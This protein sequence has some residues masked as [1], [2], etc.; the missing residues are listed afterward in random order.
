M[1][2]A[3]QLL[4]TGYCRIGQG[5][6]VPILLM[7]ASERWGKVLFSFCQFTPRRGRGQGAV[8]DALRVQ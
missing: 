6:G 5:H 7:P 2:N 1:Q 8:L 4:D 3:Q